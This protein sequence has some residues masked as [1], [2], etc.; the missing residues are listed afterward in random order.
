MERRTF[1]G[2]EVVVENPKG[3]TR[4]WHDRAAGK[5]GSTTMRHDYGFLADQLGTDGEEVDCYLGDDEAAS[6]VYVVHQRRTPDYKA[7]DEDKVFLGFGS[8]ADAKAAYLAHRDDGEQAYGGMSAIPLEAFKAKLRRRSGSGKIRHEAQMKHGDIRGRLV[9][10]D[11][12]K[13]PDGRVREHVWDR[14]CVPGHDEKDGQST[15]FDPETL[16]QMIDN[17]VER[18]DLI[19]IDW[20]HQS[21]Y[22]KMNGQPA[23]ALGFYGALALVW[24]G[25]LVKIGSVPGGE[26]SGSEPGIDLAQDGLW[27]YRCEVTDGDADCPLGQ[28]LLPGF[29]Y[30]SPT[31]TPEGVTRDG[32]EVGYSLAAVAATNTPWQSGTVLTMESQPAGMVPALK[33]EGLMAKLAKVAKLLKMEGDA[34]DA[35]VKQAL[36]SKMDDAAMESA[37]PPEGFDYGAHAAKLE[38]LAQA[39]EDAHLEEEG[40]EPP[41]QVMR[42]MAAHARKMAKLAAPPAADPDKDGDEHKMAD[43]PEEKKEMADGEE[44]EKL[45]A[46]MEAQDATIKALSKRLAKF[47]KAEAD[48]E[49][50][51]AAAAER[52][53]EQLADQAVAGGYGKDDP[54]ARTALIKFARTD[55]EAARKLV[56][57]FLPKTGAPAHLF[58]RLSA[59]GA[60]AGSKDARS[61]V[62]LVSKPRVHRAMGRTFIEQD[63]DFADEIE[64]LADSKDP[65]TMERVDKYLLPTQ[66]TNKA[67]RLLAAEKIVRAE[68]PELA[69]SAE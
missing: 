27:A 51:E 14:V 28:Q 62:P 36:E 37:A 20:N 65:V 8:E 9:A 40:D 45:E 46:K 33:K 32:Q 47:E 5:S 43:E 24:E 58:D 30:L 31:F 60:P 4:E 26:A 35:A 50:A 69:E 64:K 13:G 38:E 29:K 39:Y 19:P 15:D 11:N 12:A 17:F 52:R 56:A 6:F 34:D 57:P 66:R 63:A 67:Y 7:H 23:P 3:S 22:A 49:A 59:Q 44:K 55:L 25:K 68:R 41:H 18:G 48:R 1:A 21:N 16:G 42:R 54:S 53:F 10:F 2:L 61:E